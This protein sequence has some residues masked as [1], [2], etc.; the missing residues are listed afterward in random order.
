MKIGALIVTT[1]LSPV[2]GVTAL[3]SEVGPVTA[4]QRMISVFQCT[5]VSM[6][7]LVVGPEDKKAERQLAQSCSLPPSGTDTYGGYPPVRRCLRFFGFSA[8]EY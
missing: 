7:G 6:I 3:L 2:S 8:S 1:G 4:G 5:G